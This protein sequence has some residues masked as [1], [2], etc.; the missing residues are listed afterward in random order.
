MGFDGQAWGEAIARDGIFDAGKGRLMQ[1]FGAVNYKRTA[2]YDGIQV[3]M[4]MDALNA[5]A[6][7]AKPGG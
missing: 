3:A 5:A 4:Q 6:K 1:Q 7:T 2:L